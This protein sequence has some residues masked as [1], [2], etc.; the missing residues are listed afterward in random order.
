M[1]I[2]SGVEQPGR[3][4]RLSRLLT[5]AKPGSVVVQL[6]DRELSAA[7]R[8]ALARELR[9]ETASAGQRL[10]I[11]D[12]LDLALLV[13]ADGLHLP[14]A[15][16]PIEAVR[17]RCPTLWLSAARHSLSPLG[18]SPA[19]GA[20]PDAW[21]LSPIVSPR[22][23][24]PALGLTALAAAREELQAPV[25]ALGGV[26]AASAAAC[27][28]HGACGVAVMGAVMDPGEDLPALLAALSILTA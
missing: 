27:L 1:A 24:R 20:L 9:A 11:N 8:L 4:A 16:L 5:L 18:D 3:R 22:K 25:Y 14:E 26:T 13:G 19:S 10:V 28:A 6:R 23:G 17:E 2:T 15:G 7:A 12:R 21:V